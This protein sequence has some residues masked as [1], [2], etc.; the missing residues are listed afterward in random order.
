MRKVLIVGAASAIAQATARYMASN[1]DRIYLLARDADKLDIIAGDL[2]ARG[3]D[4][5]ETEVFDANDWARHAQVVAEAVGKLEG[6][7]T[8]LIAHGTL[9]DQGK[10]E[11]SVEQVRGEFE[12]NA[13]STISLL[14]VLAPI[15]QEQGHGT[16]AVISSVAGDRGRQSNYVYGAAKAAVTT[17]LSGLRNRLQQ[18]GVQ[19]LT[20]KPGFV[21]T[22]MTAEFPKNFLWASADDVGGKIY[23]AIEKGKDV[24]YVPWFWT[25]IMMIIRAVPEGVFK[26]LK[27]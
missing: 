13:L 4:Q 21:D 16:I 24:L 6:L 17:Y 18:H 25:I 22:P 1:G 14:T 2:K 8:V 9:P 3:A 10:C 23:Q 7:D 12:T 19:V 15:F 11:G 27:L 26:R 20:I 5:V